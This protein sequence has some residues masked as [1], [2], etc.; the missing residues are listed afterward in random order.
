MFAGI[1]RTVITRGRERAFRYRAFLK[2]LSSTLDGRVV[3]EVESRLFVEATILSNVLVDQTASKFAV[4]IQDEGA[5]EKVARPI[6]NSLSGCLATILPIGRIGQPIGL[7]R[8]IKFHAASGGKTDK[9]P[10][11]ISEFSGLFNLVDVEGVN[12]ELPLDKQF[13]TLT[14]TLLNDEAQTRDRFFYLSTNAVFAITFLGDTIDGADQIVKPTAYNLAGDRRR[15]E[16][17]VGAEEGENV[18]L[19]GAA[20][21]FAG[22][23]PIQ[24]RF[25]LSKDLTLEE[26]VTNFFKNFIVQLKGEAT[27]I[28]LAGIRED[29]AIAER[30]VEVAVIKRF[31]KEDVGSRRN[32]GETLSISILSL[33]GVKD[34]FGSAVV[35]KRGH[36][37]IPETTVVSVVDQVIQYRLH[38]L[39]LY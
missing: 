7:Q 31:Q 15:D 14:A 12:Q 23:K 36:V 4:G 18:A 24:Q 32:V 22:A 33:E 8:C 20:D 29:L 6:V 28:L 1:E 2:Q 34:F 16:G 10:K 37:N 30:T 5:P 3:V 38:V 9:N 13:T 21:N 11:F 35:Q 39:R 17:A 19:V 27:S 26:E 25:A